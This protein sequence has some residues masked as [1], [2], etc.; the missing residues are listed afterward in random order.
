MGSVSDITQPD[1]VRQAMAEYDRIGKDD[2]LRKYG[3]GT[4]TK[5]FLK[6]DGKLYDSKAI[7]GVA[8]QRALRVEEYERDGECAVADSSKNGG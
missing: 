3:Y 2:R 7:V 1:A 8:Y 5:Y 4:A 6:D